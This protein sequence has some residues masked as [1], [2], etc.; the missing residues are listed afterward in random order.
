MPARGELR[1]SLI[2]GRGWRTASRG[3]RTI[4]R[5]SRT[6]RAAMSGGRRCARLEVGAVVRE[7]REFGVGGDGEQV[8]GLRQ[9]QDR[10]PGE[11]RRAGEGHHRADGADVVPMGIGGLVG[12]RSR[13]GCLDR[14]FLRIGLAR[15]ALAIADAGL[16]AGAASTSSAWKCPNESTN[17]TASANSASRAPCFSFDRT[18][19]IAECAP[20]RDARPKYRRRR[21]YNVTSQRKGRAVNRHRPRAAIFAAVLPWAGC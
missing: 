4:M 7:M 20:H 1:L 16:A 14:R 21:C 8:I 6:R 18:H 3:R 9:P 11:H 5:R 19:F 15:A 13:R 2:S 10:R 12:L 17:C